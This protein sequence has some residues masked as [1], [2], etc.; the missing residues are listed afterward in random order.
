MWYAQSVHGIGVIS[1]E[2]RKQ[3]QMNESL[4]RQIDAL[5]TLTL[6]QLHHK[7]LELFGE[8]CSSRHRQHVVRRIGW[9]LQVLAEGGLSERAHRRALEIADDADLRILPRIVLWKIQL[10]RSRPAYCPLRTAEFPNREQCSSEN[11]KASVSAL[12]F[13]STGS[14]AMVAFSSRSVP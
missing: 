9:R 6:Q 13:W 12:L 5:R 2:R 11:S 4:S 7:H 10:H 14:S 8:P 1:L 3:P